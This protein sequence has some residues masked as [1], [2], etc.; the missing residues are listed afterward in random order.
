MVGE[1]SVEVILDVPSIPAIA[2]GPLVSSERY[3][4]LICRYS[5]SESEASGTHGGSSRGRG[6]IRG[7]IDD[8]VEVVLEGKRSLCW[9]I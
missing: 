5:Q 9:C 7:I 4:H 3:R 2:C 6:A 1:N 8:I